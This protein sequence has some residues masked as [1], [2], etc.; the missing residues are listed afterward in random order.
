MDHQLLAMR[1][2][3]R[4][5]EAGNFTKAAESLK[6]PNATVTKLVQ[7][8]EAHL[9]VKLLQRTTRRVTV[10]PDGA[11]YY[12]RTSRLLNELEDI[13]SS[14]AHAQASPRGR[15]RVDVSA[16]IA[17]YIL[18]P[19][20]PQF[21]ERY[22][23]VQ[24]DLGVTDRVIDLIGE[25]VDCVLRGGPIVD[26]SLVAKRVAEFCFLTCAAP[27]Y[28]ARHGAPTHPRDLE[29]DHHVVSYCAARTGRHMPFDFSKDGER[30]EVTGR[31]ALSVNE[32]NAY[33]AAA[34]AGL[35][36]V[37]T[38]ACMAHAHIERGELVPVLTDWQTDALPLYVVYPPNRHQSARLRAFV[39][40]VSALFAK[41]QLTRMK[42]KA[43]DY[44]PLETV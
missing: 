29:N 24:I 41:N 35:G 17:R 36:V 11:A 30:I 9:G 8:L 10:T 16:V 14:M 4:V 44:S 25:N 32:G 1:V 5:V 27:A 7:G 23:D 40:W 2:F 34:L 19:A 43:P 33:I 22:P 31:Y 39:E 26:E 37:Q 13:E 6:M 28:L 42:H 18:I 12:E 3:A 21:H 15:L 38:F 20:L